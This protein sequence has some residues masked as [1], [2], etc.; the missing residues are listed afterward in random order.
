MDARVDRVVGRIAMYHQMSVQSVALR[1]DAAGP[2][3]QF[4]ELG[5]I[6]PVPGAG[7]GHDVLLEHHRAEVV[8]AEVEGELADVLTGRQP[9]ALQVTDVVEE[10][11][12]DGDQA[13]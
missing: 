11:S 12:G 9:R 1:R 4:D 5:A 6:A 8:R 13:Q 10:Q 3:N 7:A 2:A